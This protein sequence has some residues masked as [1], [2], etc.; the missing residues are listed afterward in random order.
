[1]VRVK[2]MCFLIIM[3]ALFISYQSNPLGT[4]LIGGVFILIY[5]YLKSRKNRGSGRG[6]GGLLFR[7][8]SSSVSSPSNDLMTLLMVQAILDR[9]SQNNNT[10]SNKEKNTEKN[11]M[12]RLKQEVLSLFEEE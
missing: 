7:K 8:G 1:M 9:G 4:I 12:E 5:A 6:S 11:E 3:F 10:P 2:G